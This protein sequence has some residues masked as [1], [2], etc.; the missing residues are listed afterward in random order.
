VSQHEL[1]CNVADGVNAG[2]TGS[3]CAIHLYEAPFQLDAQLLEAL[4]LAVR[5]HADGD[6]HF[7]RLYLPLAPADVHLQPRLA[8]AAAQ[9]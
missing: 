2:D 8:L 7:V 3:H 5:G 4:A 6:Q 9:A 1:P